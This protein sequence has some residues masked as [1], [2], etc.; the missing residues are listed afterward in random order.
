M[1]VIGIGL[2]CFSSR[3]AVENKTELTDP[4]RVDFKLESPGTTMDLK[5]FSC[6]KV[7]IWD[8]LMEATFENASWPKC[9][10]T[11]CYLLW[12]NRI[13]HSLKKRYI[14]P[15]PACGGKCGVLGTESAYCF[16]YNPHR[17]PTKCYLHNCPI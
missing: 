17:W 2:S 16:S 1:D 10:I 7:F 12:K 13:L 4:A 3:V 9:Y 14:H 6:H 11:R 8:L 5:N 15:M